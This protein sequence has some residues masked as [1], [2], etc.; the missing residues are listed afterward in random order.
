MDQRIEDPAL[1]WAAD[2]AGRP[3]DRFV[4][5]LTPETIARIRIAYMRRNGTTIPLPAVLP[6]VEAKQPAPPIVEPVPAVDTDPE[7][8]RAEND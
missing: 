6:T 5:G 1:L 3:Y 4:T 8:V 2:R 7:S